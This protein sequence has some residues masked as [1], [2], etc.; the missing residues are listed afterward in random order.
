MKYRDLPDQH[1]ARQFSEDMLNN[2]SIENDLLIFNGKICVPITAR[3]W[4][5]SILHSAHAGKEAMLAEAKKYYY[6]AN[7]QIEVAETARSCLKCIENSGTNQKQPEKLNQGRYPGEIVA[8]DPFEITGCKK[9][10]LGIVDSYSVFPWCN[11]M[12]DCKTSTIIKNINQFIDYTNLRPLILQSD[13]GVQFASDDYKSWCKSMNITPQLSSPYHQQSNGAIESHV[14][15]LKKLIIEH[16]GQLSSEKFRNAMN[17]FRNHV[18][19]RVGKSRH[20][21]LFGWPG[22]SDLPVMDTQICPID[23]EEAIMRKIEN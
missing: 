3:R 4:I 9:Y 18:S 1:P 17:R 6:W 20:E 10:F 16:N 22:R 11:A 2:I 8:I 23:R 15:E 21:M 14:K 5:T 19:A 12:S 13:S 7:M